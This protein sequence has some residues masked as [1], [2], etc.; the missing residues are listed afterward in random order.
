M[1]RALNYAIL[2]IFLSIFSVP[3]YALDP[4]VADAV[5]IKNADEMRIS[6]EVKNA[7]TKE[8]DEAIKSGISTTFTFFIELH[9]KRGYWFDETLI[10]TQFRHTIKYDSL[11]EE[12]EISLGE[13]PNN[14]IRVK[15]FYRA[16]RIMANGDNISIKPVPN[17]KKG[18][19]YQLRIKATLDAVNLPFPLNYMLFFVSFWNYETDWYEKEFSLYEK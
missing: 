8:I 11:K 1:S 16:K 4:R 10:S 19:H 9:R 6:F 3:A 2:I 12:F 17:L 15:E 7:F 5:I 18:E 14:T 13:R